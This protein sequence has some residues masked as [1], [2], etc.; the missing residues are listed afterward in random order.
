MILS[1]VPQQKTYN[2]QDPESALLWPYRTT[3][4]VLPGAKVKKENPPTESYLRHHPNPM[5]RASP[6]HFDYNNELSYKQKVADSVLNRVIP[7][8]Q[9]NPNR[10]VVNR[11]YNTPIGLYSEQNI[12]DSIHNQHG[13][14]TPH[15]PS[16]TTRKIHFYTPNKNYPYTSF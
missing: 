8:S 11:P 5:M 1:P 2:G 4:L 3:P 6:G 14:T 9:S 16:N 12:V 15:P 10:H 13:S 7:E